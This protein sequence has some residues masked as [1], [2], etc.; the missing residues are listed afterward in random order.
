VITK[1][2]YGGEACT[3]RGKENRKTQ[4]QRRKP[5]TNFQKNLPVAK[6]RDILRNCMIVLAYVSVF[7]EQVGLY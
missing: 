4:S 6:P 7:L 5:T 3:Q 2:I 1:A